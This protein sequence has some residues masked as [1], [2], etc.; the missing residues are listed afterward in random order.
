[1]MG[2][3]PEYRKRGAGS[4][5]LEWGTKVADQHSLVCWL[6]AS[7]MSVSLYEKHGFKT[8]GTVT[9]ELDE[10]CGG[11]QYTHSCMAREPKSKT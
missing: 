6:E 8:V 9:M 5:H 10:R 7:P 4:M 11:G 2:T 1:M 3:A